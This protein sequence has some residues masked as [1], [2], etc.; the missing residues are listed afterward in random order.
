[1]QLTNLTGA[2]DP[3]ACFLSPVLALC[4]NLVSNY[5]GF[6]YRR[7]FMNGTVSIVFPASFSWWR[8]SMA[9][10]NPPNSCFLHQWL[11]AEGYGCG[12]QRVELLSARSRHDQAGQKEAD[13]HPLD[14]S[15]IHATDFADRME[16][17]ILPLLKAGAVV[18]CDRY[19]YTRCA[20]RGARDDRQWVREL[21]SFAVKPTA[22]F[23]FR[24]P[25][26]VAM[27]RILDGRSGVNTTRRG[28]T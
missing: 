23:Y 10:E 24:V 16:H 21:Y 4:Y 5:A 14:F 13:A 1:M 15:L 8:E 12:L 11:Q 27:K 9:Q 2:R 22:A 3:R 25:L 7:A 17:N 28:W 26:D 18:L 6:S 20:R 19:I